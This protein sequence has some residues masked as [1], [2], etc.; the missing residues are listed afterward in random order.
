LSIREDGASKQV[1][2]LTNL[3]K[4]DQR[5]GT[6]YVVDLSAS[7]KEAGGLTAVKKGLT[8]IARRSARR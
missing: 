1:K 3:R 6:V 8:D 4:T 7:M 2:D 5:L